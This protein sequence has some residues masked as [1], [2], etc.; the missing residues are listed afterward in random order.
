MNKDEIKSKAKGKA[1]SSFAEFK[2][3]ALKGNIMDLAVGMVMGSAFTAIVTAVV[4][5]LLS[6]LIGAL[7]SDI[8]LTA[9]SL[10]VGEVEFVYGAVLNALI[11]FII[12]ALVMFLIVKAL[13]KANRKNEEEEEATTKECPYCLSAIPIK[14]TRCPH[15]TSELTEKE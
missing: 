1:K 11:S 4:D 9:L 12:V 6:P 7:T 13:A 10:K 14:A 2:E 5:N 15:C 8:D 3:F